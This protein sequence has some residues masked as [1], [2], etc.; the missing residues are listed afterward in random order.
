MKYEGNP[1]VGP[2]RSLAGACRGSSLALA[3]PVALCGDAN[4]NETMRSSVRRLLPVVLA[5]FLLAGCVGV[6]QDRPPSELRHDVTTTYGNVDS[7]SATVELHVVGAENRTVTYR[8]AHRGGETRVTYRSPSPLAGTTVL[9]TDGTTVLVDPTHDGATYV[10]SAASSN[11]LGTLVAMLDEGTTYDGTDRIDGDDGFAVAYSVEGVNA[12]LVVGGDP[13]AYRFSARRAD[14]GAT[15]V[16][17]DPE[18]DLPVKAVSTTTRNGTTT[19]VTL[20]LR[21]LTLNP[22]FDDDRFTVDALTGERAPTPVRAESRDALAENAT[23]P[24]PSPDLPAGY[25]FAAG[26]VLRSDGHESVELVY[27][28]G[29][30]Q[31]RVTVATP[32]RKM[33]PAG[34]TVSVDGATATVA[35]VDADGAN[36]TVTWTCSGRTY[37]V[38]GPLS[39]ADLL[40]V[41]RS[42]GCH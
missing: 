34:E 35:A 33:L 16:W 12:S 3:P 29:T 27:A 4:T 9:S 18:R 28:N 31:V 22:S 41:A 32:S 14:A 20:R 17:V 21:N 19:R 6:A 10:R 8:V 30:R 24:V 7:Y 1:C 11:V 36:R 39:Q 26:D 37:G 15:R 5:V 25:E 2:R 40:A 13:A 38:S 23:I 42:I